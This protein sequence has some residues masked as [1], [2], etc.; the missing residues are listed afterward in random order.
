MKGLDYD[1]KKKFIKDVLSKKYLLTELASKYKISISSANRYWND[2]KLYGE[3]S[4]LP[5]TQQAKN[6]KFRTYMSEHTKVDF[7]SDNEILLDNIESKYPTSD[8]QELKLEL[9][10]KDIE[11]ERLK[12]GYK[13]KGV[14]QKKEYVILEKKNTK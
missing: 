12:K 14:G 6:E 8:I 2:Y 3:D 13:V 5:F 11:I 9:I 10:K 1:G 4:F 7:R